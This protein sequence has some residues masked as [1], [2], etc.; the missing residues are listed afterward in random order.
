MGG[1][2]FLGKDFL[3]RS[4]GPINMLAASSSY[5]PVSDRRMFF[6]YFLH[7]LLFYLFLILIPVTLGFALGTLVRPI[8]PNRYLLISAAQWASF[9]LGLS[10]SMFVSSILSGR[11]KWKWI[12]MPVGLVPLFS[13]QM[14]TGEITGF[15][16][17]VLALN[18]NSWIWILATLG[19]IVLY[20]IGGI[21]LYEGGTTTYKAE[22]SGSYNS[23][24]RFVSRFIGDPITNSLFSREIMNL[25]RG[26]AYIRIVFSLFFPLLVMLGLVGM[27][28]GFDQGSLDFNMPFFAVMVSFFTMSIYTNLVNTDFLEFDQTLPIRTSDL[29]QIKVKVY[30]VLAIPLATV[31]LVIV[32]LA[33]GDLI[34]LVY[35]LPLMIVMVPYMGYVTAYLTGLWTN[36]MLFDASVFLKY[37]VLTVLPLMMA[38]LLSFLMESI[39]IVSIIGLGSIVIAGIVSTLFLSGSLEKKWSD[40]VLQSAGSG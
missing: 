1:I 12:L 24:R 22:S 31:F 23:T 29:I 27:I 17:T 7:D 38:T 4:L 39:F 14:I 13:I 34:G 28:S 26:K 25:F 10:L 32:A 20:S 5:H 19:L 6:A 18:E 35:A 2:A 37:L 33:T 30:L 15:I 8:S 11:M 21:L 40:A 16:P 36:S 3:E 9:L